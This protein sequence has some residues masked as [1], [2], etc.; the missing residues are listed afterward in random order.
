M[1]NI[2][3]EAATA[4]GEASLPY[5]KPTLKKWGRLRDQ[6]KKKV[7]ITNNADHTTTVNW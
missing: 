7:S 4:K 6:T 1:K 5:E 2:D 3:H